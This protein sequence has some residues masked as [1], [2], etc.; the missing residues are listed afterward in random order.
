MLAQLTKYSWATDFQLSS[1]LAQS[2]MDTSETCYVLNL[3]FSYKYVFGISLSVKKCF[4]EKY[5]DL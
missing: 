5:N 4:S 1:F 2:N 3:F